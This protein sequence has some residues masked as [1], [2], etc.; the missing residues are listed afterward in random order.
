MYHYQLQVSKKSFTLDQLFLAI[1]REKAKSLDVTRSPLERTQSMRVCACCVVGIVMERG[2]DLVLLARSCTG[3][4]TAAL[5][6]D[7]GS[8]LGL[9]NPASSP[10]L[11][12]TLFT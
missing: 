5:A 3:I 12:V 4:H 7:G 1:E 2:A 8:G 10:H 6:T 11:G 9:A